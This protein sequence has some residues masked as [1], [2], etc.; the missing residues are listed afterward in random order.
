M[1]T[2]AQMSCRKMPGIM[3][4]CTAVTVVRFFCRLEVLQQPSVPTHLS[5]GVWQA[6]HDLPDLC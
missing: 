3:P 6:H 4:V 1:V 2:M 5:E